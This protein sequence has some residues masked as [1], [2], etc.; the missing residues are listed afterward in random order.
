MESLGTELSQGNGLYELMYCQE[1]C[2]LIILFTRQEDLKKN[3]CVHVINKSINT[4]TQVYKE[5]H[6]FIFIFTSYHVSD[7]YKESGAHV[8]H[9]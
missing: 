4:L 1:G 3:P 7:I 6:L 8:K 9:N 2:D 5:Q